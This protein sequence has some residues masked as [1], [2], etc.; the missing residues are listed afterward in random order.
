VE[1]KHKYGS[2]SDEDDQYKTTLQIETAHGVLTV[3]AP[4]VGR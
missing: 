4:L 3:E 2:P 1:N